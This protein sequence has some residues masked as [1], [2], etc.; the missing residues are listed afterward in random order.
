MYDK[1]THFLDQYKTK[2][3]TNNERGHGVI[4]FGQTYKYPGSKATDPLSMDIPGPLMD[5]VHEIRKQHPEAVINQCLINYY[6]DQNSLL[7]KHS[8]NEDCIVPGSHIYTVSVGATRKVTFSRINSSSSDPE[9]TVP[10]T[11]K[12]MYVMSK[13]SQSVWEHRIDQSD[14]EC[15]HRFSVTFRYISNN[16]ENATLILGDS[17]T[18][19]LN[20]GS[21]RKTFG[22]RT[23]GKR[24]ECFTIE[25]IDPKLCVGY[26]N[27]IVHCGINNI[28]RNGAN[29]ELCVQQLVNKLSRICKLCPESKVT[30]SPILP[31]K[32]TWLNEKAIV[33]NQLLFKFCSQTQ[34]IGTLDFNSFVDSDGLLRSEY[35]RYF[36]KSDAIHLGSAGIY[37]LSRIIVDK[38]YMSPIDGRSYSKVTESNISQSNRSRV[39]SSLYDE[40]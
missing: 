9:I 12:S 15:S 19:F 10:V 17:N 2:F 6:P 7:P 39:F 20:F 31:T 13:W 36:N 27:I 3:M 21:G 16:T 30:V 5:V 14:D 37:K 33:F 26:R 35:G 23:P 4:S 1:L 29:I 40:Y 24:V 28:K 25:S 11:N 8:D 34:Q 32:L 18:R 22:Y 38:I